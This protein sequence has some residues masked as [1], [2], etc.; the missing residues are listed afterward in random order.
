M[1]YYIIGSV[2][3]LFSFVGFWYFGRVHLVS[4]LIEQHQY[5]QDAPR[6]I[7]ISYKSKNSMEACALAETLMLLGHRVWLGQYRIPLF[8]DAQ[9]EEYLDSGM[10]QCDKAIL[11]TNQL[12]SDSTWCKYEINEILRN[13]RKGAVFQIHI[14]DDSNLYDVLSA[15]ILPLYK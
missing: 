13:Y 8:E 3:V 1:L 12:Y 10:K 4:T 15:E 5:F 11:M 14:P 7:F 9:F 2:A 6:Q